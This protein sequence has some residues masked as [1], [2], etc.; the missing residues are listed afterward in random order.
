MVWLKSHSADAR[1]S[2]TAFF[3]IAVLLAVGCA[4]VAYGLSQLADSSKMAFSTLGAFRYFAFL[5]T[6]WLFMAGSCGLFKTHPIS[7]FFVAVIIIS[8]IAGEAWALIVV[9][10]FALAS[11]LVGGYVL[12]VISPKRPIEPVIFLLVGAGL[13]GVVVSITSHFPVN[14]RFTYLI[15]LGGPLILGRR[16]VIDMLIH[17]YKTIT[18][19]RVIGTRVDWLELAIYVVLLVHIVIAFVPETGH[20]ALATH[21]FVSAHLSTRHKWGFDVSTYI[22]AVM[23]ML[24]DWIYSIGYMLA[25]ESASRLINVG[26]ISILALLVRKI[27]IWCGGS[28]SGASWSVLIFLS[29]PL[30]FTESSSLY[31][32]SVWASFIV[33]GTFVTCRICVGDNNVAKTDLTTAGIILGLAAATKAVTFT[34]LPVLLALL[35]IQYQNWL[36]RKNS[37]LIFSGLICFLAI[38][39]LPYAVSYLTT[40]NPLFPFYNA[41]FQSPLYPPENFSDLRW[42]RGLR[43]DSIYDITFNSPRFIE[44]ASV[45]VPGFQWLIFFAPAIVV[46]IITRQVRTIM[47]LAVGLSMLFMTT[48]LISYLRYL[49]PTLVL[50]TAVIGVAVSCYDRY[51]G[52]IRN[53]LISIM[54]M[55]VFLNLWFINS[56]AQYFDFP[57]QTL[58]SDEKRVAFLTDQLPI[59]VAVKLVNQLNINGTPVAIFDQP[60][61]AGLVADAIYP[62]W[63][64]QRFRDEL[65]RASTQT[66]VEA[67]LLKRNVQFVL[68]NAEYD[69][70]NIRKLVELATIHLVDV[71][72]ISVRVAGSKLRFVREMIKTPRFGMANQW[73]TNAGAFLTPHGEI[74]VT[75]TSPAT[76]TVPVV[77]GKLYQNTVVARC[78]NQQGQG[79][80]QINWMDVDSKYLSTSAKIFT[81]VNDPTSY[82]MNVVAPDG[83]VNAIVYTSG[84]TEVPIAYSENSL[85]Q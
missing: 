35:L 9:G 26:F 53:G 14:Y 52:I 56:A 34:I 55:V 28:K 19:S 37:T 4:F 44:S 61:A 8:L 83:A 33:A 73:Q 78:I 24:G 13:Y 80:I 63:Y 66:E 60:M 57:L 2:R 39:I 10:C 76:Q 58:L 40:S 48:F 70:P 29:T 3:C 65:F 64:N 68:L 84:H 72:T 22:W 36:K 50:L 54:S 31:I 67:A 85:K 77:E 42:G 45:G 51:D 30:T 18:Q 59:R 23:P 82:S 74:V 41:F 5:I 17:C 71:G 32:E 62:N 46:L 20:D 69:Q 12:N 7:A 25:G 38:A 49:F 79:R 81:C 6:C 16:Y 43:W 75:A 21:L 27:V 47:L 11:I 15:L 1:F